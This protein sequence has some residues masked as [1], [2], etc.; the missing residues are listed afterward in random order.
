MSIDA[1]TLVE[2]Q[3]I[4]LENMPD[5]LHIYRK[6]IVTDSS[7]NMSDGFGGIILDQDKDQ[8][9][10]QREWIASCNCRATI[11]K[12]N[13]DASEYTTWVQYTTETRVMFIVPYDTDIQPSDGVRFIN[14]ITGEELCFEVKVIARH[15][16]G[17]SLQ[18]NCIKIDELPELDEV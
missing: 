15:S 3:A 10:D 6:K 12:A 7:N 13:R 5:T 14:N 16:E 8:F 9:K 17:I 18:L 11:P 4:M 2:L 1:E